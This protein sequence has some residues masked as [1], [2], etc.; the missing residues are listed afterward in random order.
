[1]MPDDKIGGNMTEFAS[2]EEFEA[3]FKDNYKPLDYEDVK[4]AF[5]AFYKE[6]DGKIFHEDYEINGSVSKDDFLENLSKTAMFTFQDALTEAFYEK[7]PDVYETAFMIFEKNGGKHSAITSV[8]DETYQNLYQEF[9]NQFF[10]E[11]IA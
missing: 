9:L 1:M 2:K 3:F 4:E 7:N 11:M 5:E 10:D 6:H 8:F